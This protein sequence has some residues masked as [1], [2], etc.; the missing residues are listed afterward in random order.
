M[1][2]ETRNKTAENLSD[3]LRAS[4]P[5]QA[6]AEDVNSQTQ[7]ARSRSC[8]NNNSTRMEC[9]QSPEPSPTEADDSA[10]CSPLTI[11]RR[12]DL[13]GRDTT[14]S[15]SFPGP[16]YSL[17]GLYGSSHIPGG[18]P[19][20]ETARGTGP[21]LVPVPMLRGGSG[22]PVLGPFTP[23]RANR[24]IED[25]FFMT[26]EH[27]DV[28]GKTTYDAIE[29]HTK[30]QIGATTMK[31]EQLVGVL[32]QHIA[33]LRSQIS[34]SSE[35]IEHN[36]N[37]TQS[38]DLKLGQFE[39]FLKNEIVS[40]MTEQ[41]KKIAEVE[42]SLK[43]MQT[44]LVHMQQSLEKLTES[45]SVS[46]QVNADPLAAP[47]A[48]GLMS[49]AASAHHSQPTLTTYYGNEWSREE[50]TPMPPLQDRSLSNN[51]NSHNDAR[52]DYGNNWQSH[53][54]NERS[55]YQGRHRGEAS[56]YAGTNPYHFGNGSQYSTGY[57]NGYSTYNPTPAS[58]EHLYTYGQ[59]SG[60]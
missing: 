45:K 26:N 34:L 13:E 40:P 11:P 6:A 18:T 35:K 1:R 22:A 8:P 44:A 49:Q 46:R 54:W 53:G 47:A 3:C 38:I 5:Q 42:S 60:Q 21:C 7:S 2:Q 51:Y 27:L 24:T 58:P 57:M 10:R 9:L 30:Q 28:V 55:S 16:P 37:H 20:V 59:K 50:Q 43:S 56:S 52:G 39:K 41:S 32:E 14:E 17:D 23:V 48:T 31:H 19:I 12:S 25:H 15:K 4:T 29:M 36:A 33:D